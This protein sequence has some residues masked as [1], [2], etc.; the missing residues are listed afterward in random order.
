MIF[1]GWKLPWKEKDI[2][3]VEYYEAEIGDFRGGSGVLFS[4]N[5]QPTCQ[6]RGR[7]RLLV[8]V[9]DHGYIWPSFD[10]QDQPMRYFHQLNNML[11]EADEIAAAMLKE[12]KTP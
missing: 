7:W 6:L 4:F 8:E 2:E 3:G 1:A 12:K 5:Y 9:N 10:H 11:S